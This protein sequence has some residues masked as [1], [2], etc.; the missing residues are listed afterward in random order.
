MNNADENKLQSLKDLNAS[1]KEFN[2]LLEELIQSRQ[3]DKLNWLRTLNAG[4]RDVN[5]ILVGL[6]ESREKDVVINKLHQTASS[7]A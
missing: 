6:L 3:K 1:I 5:A 2:T 7:S 4:L